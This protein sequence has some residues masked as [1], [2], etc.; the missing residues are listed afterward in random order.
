M[1]IQEYLNYRQFLLDEARDEDG[2]IS[3]STF[4]RV[5]LPALNETKLIESEECNEAYCFLEKEQLRIDGYLVNESGERLQIF[6]INEESL[7]LT[8]TQE[9]LLI[10]QKSYYEKH[11]NRAINF[12]KKAIKKQLDTLVQD[13]SPAKP[14]ISLLGSSDAMDQF[15]VI[16][17]FLISATVTIESRGESRSLKR[18]D[19]ADDSLSVS[20]TKARELHK[21]DLI[22][23][24]RLIDLNF[25]Y[26]VVTSQGN[27]EVLTIDFTIPPFN[28]PIPC[29]QAADE[30][31]FES[32]LCV[33]PGT[34]LA[35]LYQKYS[36]RMLEKNVR[37]FLQLKGVNKGMQETISRSPEKFIAYNNG[38]T[39]TATGKELYPEN[40]AMFIKS[41]TDFQIVNGGQTTATIFFSRKAKSNINQIRVMAKITV[42]KDATEEELDELISN[43]STYS[44]AQSRVSKV[45][46]RSRSIQLVRLKTLSESILTP[47]G[48]KWFFERAKGEFNT[49]IRKA[50]QQKARINREYPRERRFTKEEL[51]RYHTAWGDTPYLVKKGGEKVF[52]FFIEEITGERKTRK[53]TGTE[54]DRSFYENLIARI[55]MF[56]QLERIYGSG[57]RAIGQIRS[58]VVPYS[59]AIL[60]K[61][62]SG[63]KNRL[64][65][66]LF[67]IWK[68]ESMEEDL[69][70]FFRDLM[71][72]MNDLIKKY[73]HS[74]DYGEYSKK[75]ELWTRISVCPE[76]ET[77]IQSEIFKKIAD[78]YALTAESKKRNNEKPRAAP[79][80]EI[81]KASIGVFARTQ[82]F[83]KSLAAE[84]GKELKISERNKIEQIIA[85]IQTNTDI[86]S[87]HLLFESELLERIR[88]ERPDFFD[89]QTDP[90]NSLYQT[91]DFILKHY[92][93]SIERGLSIKSEFDFLRELADRKGIKYSSSFSEIGK[94]LEAGK[95]PNIKQLKNIS[96]YVRLIHS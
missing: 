85:H 80:F 59:I 43:I 22:I 93:R 83:Y 35:E 79:D 68:T 24:K 38:L 76:I 4:L 19:F 27:R 33:L 81:L 53:S 54:I 17:L 49:M 56:R 13:S 46:L 9:K 20:F 77:L 2:F 36:S 86:S 60:Y 70:I 34:L 84:F 66:N 31:N 30:Q 6:L 41:L 29:I 61:Y 74:D 32:Y 45:D 72:L 3:D 12:L 63:N 64:P 89:R 21:K 50:P 90:D 23:Y 57:P 15:D 52:R 96:H 16:E 44:N 69:E 94:A 58:A 62:T 5:C 92:N 7:D 39:I 95:L 91:Y 71:T 65:F 87:S 42:A 82:E 37:S 75:E 73:S 48:N 51:A 40:G 11:F 55:I 67:R 10:S 26:N 88:I 18:V 1:E 14:I 47:G 78:K 25:L 28:Y 8:S